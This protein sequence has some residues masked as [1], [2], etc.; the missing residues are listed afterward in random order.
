MFYF[1]GHLSFTFLYGSLLKKLFVLL[2]STSIDSFFLLTFDWNKN[3]FKEK[4]EGTA[5]LFKNFWIL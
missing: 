3:M 5:C 1:F 4:S 2:V